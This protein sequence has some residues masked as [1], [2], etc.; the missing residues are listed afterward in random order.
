MAGF[1]LVEMGVA[2][3]VLGLVLTGLATYWKWQAHHELAQQVRSGMD[4][5]NAAL[6]AY[7]QAQ[8]RL[9]CPDTDGD[10]IEGAAGSCPVGVSMGR[11]P[12]KTVGVF[13]AAAREMTYA[14]YRKVNAAD[15][16]ADVDL[17][18]AQDRYSPLVAEG[19]PLGANEIL[20]GNSN[21]LDFCR[22]LDLPTRVA[23]A[24]STASAV[25]SDRLSVWQPGQPASR[26]NVAY[27]LA[28]GG[29][30]DADGDG[31][32]L[33]G[34]N[35][36]ATE[37]EPA[38]ELPTR[39]PSEGYDDTVVAGTF[40][41][42][43][44]ELDCGRGLSVIGHGHANAAL[45]SAMLRQGI[46]DYRRQ[47]QLLADAAGADVAA[48]TA[49]LLM[50]GSGLGKA[51]A[52]SLDATSVLL[53]SQGTASAVLAPAVL[54]I[55]ANTSATVTATVTLAKAIAFKVEADDRYAKVAPLVDLAD[56]LSPSVNSNF[57][58]ADQAGF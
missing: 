38:F 52:T 40:Q 22:A 8:H 45:A 41:E 36:S 17:V 46:H 51:I 6:R 32:R 37:A 56:G 7:V 19:S 55:I 18:R 13:G 54:A 26:R 29:L 30:A 9:P 25:E 5:A 58:Q 43:F 20:L 48:S 24:G 44:S 39:A 10:G 23:A 34:A 15:A 47:L 14:V 2:L 12:W 57:R 42:L 16:R 31:K 21:L 53:V 50:A 11:F 4:E 27:V 3:V 35:A 28:H 49:A 1:S 33:D